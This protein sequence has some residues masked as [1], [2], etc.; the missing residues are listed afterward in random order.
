MDTQAVKYHAMTAFIVQWLRRRPIVIP[1]KI[2]RVIYE[3]GAKR[4]K[5]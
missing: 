1:G 4:R 3:R 2:P 5:R